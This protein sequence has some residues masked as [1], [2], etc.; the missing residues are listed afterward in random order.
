MTDTAPSPCISWMTLGN[1]SWGQWE[2]PTDILETAAQRNFSLHA[3]C[4]MPDHVHFLCEG[5][6]ETSDLVQFVDALK[7][8]TAYEF[9]KTH[10]QRL[11]QMLYKYQPFAAPALAIPLQQCSAR[12]L[13]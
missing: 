13:G 10:G 5:L 6:S 9:K 3:Y 8:R 7:Q 4:I 1:D 2:C 11:W 12:H